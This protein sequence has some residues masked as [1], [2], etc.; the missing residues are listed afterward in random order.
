MRTIHT[1]PLL[2]GG[3]VPLS[4]SLA[5]KTEVGTGHY[6]LTKCVSSLSLLMYY[7]EAGNCEIKA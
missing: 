4:L 5:P 3:V 6:L 7:S 2:S 1:Q